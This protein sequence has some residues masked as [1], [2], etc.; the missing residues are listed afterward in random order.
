MFN[1]AMLA[2]VTI[3]EMPPIQV[4]IYKIKT[5]FVPNSK[6]VPS[7]V[8]ILYDGPRFYCTSSLFSWILGEGGG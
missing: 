1:A 8:G 6:P 3:F 4:L 7:L 5:S 2:K